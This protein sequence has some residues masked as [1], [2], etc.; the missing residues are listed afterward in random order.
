MKLQQSYQAFQQAGAEVVALAVAPLAQVD[1]VRK[2][3]GATYPVLADPVHRA[4][5]SYGV[6]NLFNDNLAAPSVFV[7]DTDGRIVW[8]HVGK[9]GSDRPGEQAILEQLP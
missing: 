7:I 2:V 9:N 8:S 4:A 6:Y 3:T 1:G 5:E